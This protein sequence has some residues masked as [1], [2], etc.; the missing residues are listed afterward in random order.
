MTD[1]PSDPPRKEADLAR[2]IRARG[3][4]RGHAPPAIAKQIHEQCAPIFGTSQVKSHRLAHGIALSDVVAQVRAL[5]ELEG[6]PLPKLGETLLSAYESGYK[7]PGPEYLH[8]L[9]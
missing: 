5:Y 9:C 1:L 2:L 8:Y 3:V 7:R 4:A 6:K